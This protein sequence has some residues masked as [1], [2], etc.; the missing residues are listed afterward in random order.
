VVVI[1][2]ETVL[3][4]RGNQRPRFPNLRRMAVDVLSI[5]AMSAE[6]ELVLGVICE[7]LAT[8]EFMI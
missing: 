6:P 2:T 4:L 5:P 3:N 7:V 1:A 8:C